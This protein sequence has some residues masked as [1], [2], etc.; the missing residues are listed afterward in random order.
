MLY[1]FFPI[2]G[3]LLTNLLGINICKSYIDNRITKKKDYNE[4]LFLISFFNSI[5]WLFY[6]IVNKDIFIFTSIITS[7]ISTFLFMQ[8][9]YK[10]IIFEKLIYIELISIFY[11]IY[12]LSLL[13]ICT[14][15]NIPKQYF[16]KIIGISSMISSIITNL[17]PMIV[18]K[19]I[20]QTKDTSLIYLPQA[21][22]GL[23]NLLCWLVYS[24]VI[25]DLYQTLPYISSL[26]CC[27]LQLI[28]Y[29]YY[30]FKNNNLVEPNNVLV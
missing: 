12:F 6:S 23:I 2:I 22:I 8:I 24:I 11:I 29:T 25:N 15:T 30:K 10:R 19:K 27:S 4:I 16:V 7:L 5:S 26:F 21:L 1:I 3:V 9:L 17:S 28:I 20:I 13:F 18:I 14:F